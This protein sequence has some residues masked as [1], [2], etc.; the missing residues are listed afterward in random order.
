M[1]Q[2]AEPSS[3]SNV[4]AMNEPQHMWHKLVWELHYLIN[5]MSVWEDDGG[6]PAQVFRAFNT[7]VTAWHLTDWIWQSSPKSRAALKQRFKFSCN[8]TPSGIK[9]GLGRF[10][11]AVAE[12]CGALKICREI[13]NGSKHMRTDKPDPAI[14]AMASWDAVVEGVGLAKPGDLIMGLRV[15]DSG[16]EQDA[17]LWFIEALG[18]WDRLMSEEKLLEG[19]K[20]LPNKIVK[21]TPN[22]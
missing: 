1:S 13:A 22:R 19:A 12:D 11:H 2:V 21:E 9:K 14:K 4:I 7:A 17:V 18:Y 5:S 3:I 8:E 16:K 20:P 6:N 15:A 10:Q